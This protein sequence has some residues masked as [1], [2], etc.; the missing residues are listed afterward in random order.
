MKGQYG[1]T[2]NSSSYD[3][4]MNKTIDL[5]NANPDIEIRSFLYK[6]DSTPLV[7]IEDA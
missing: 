2:V 7:L 3:Y 6:S 5:L 4:D 1:S